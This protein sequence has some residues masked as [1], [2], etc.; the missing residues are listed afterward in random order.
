MAARPSTAMQPDELKS[1]DK[2]MERAEGGIS[3]NTSESG[4]NLCGLDGAKR[5]V[6]LYIETTEKLAEGVLAF[7]ATTTEWGHAT[8]SR[9]SGAPFD[10][11][12]A[13]RGLRQIGPS[14]LADRGRARS[15]TSTAYHG[16]TGEGCIPVPSFWRSSFPS[17]FSA[18]DI[19]RSNRK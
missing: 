8:R 1:E 4:Q 12:Q 7:Q 17:R 13:G 16:A 11:A 19:V 15:L 10:G 9:I 2:T 5:L 18:A 3:K 6:A 14:S